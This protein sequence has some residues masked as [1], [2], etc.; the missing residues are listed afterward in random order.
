MINVII[1]KEG[2]TIN[3]QLLYRLY[4]YYVIESVKNTKVSLKPA[5]VMEVFGGLT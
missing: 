5:V 4:I 1:L 2:L 3:T